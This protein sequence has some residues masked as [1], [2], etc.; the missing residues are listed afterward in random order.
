[1]LQAAADGL[2]NKEIS[3]NLAISEKTVKKHIANIFSNLQLNDRTHAV[4]AA[5]RKGLISISPEDDN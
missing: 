3:G 2:C 1:M 4:V 5:L